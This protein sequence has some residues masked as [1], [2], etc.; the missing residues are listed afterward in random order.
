MG[1]AGHDVTDRRGPFIT[2]LIKD[3]RV[4]IDGIVA[5]A[6]RERPLS[7]FA[8]LLPSGEVLQCLVFNTKFS[9]KV[10]LHS[11]NSSFKECLEFELF[12]CASIS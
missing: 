10:P 7:S 4:K 12:R 8:S 6:L 2:R 9:L 1:L 3:A 5:V 11:L